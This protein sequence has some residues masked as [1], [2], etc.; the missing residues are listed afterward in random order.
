M[1]EAL[2]GPVV[3]AFLFLNIFSPYSGGIIAIVG[4]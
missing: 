4:H 2:Y 1:A 3:Q